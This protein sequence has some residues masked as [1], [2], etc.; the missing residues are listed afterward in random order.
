VAKSFEPGFP[1]PLGIVLVLFGVLILLSAP[2][3]GGVR[4]RWLTEQAA[5]VKRAM[6]AGA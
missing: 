1:F 2:H 6:K 4:S 3:H 5:T